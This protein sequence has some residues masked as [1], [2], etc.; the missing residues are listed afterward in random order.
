MYLFFPSYS[1]K[2]ENT[3]RIRMYAYPNTAL[4][5]TRIRMSYLPPS[6]PGLCLLLSCKLPACLSIPTPHRIIKL[7]CTL[8]ILCLSPLI[9]ILKHPL[10][11]PLPLIPRAPH[12]SLHSLGFPKGLVLHSNTVSRSATSSI[13]LLIQTASLLHSYLKHRNLHA[14]T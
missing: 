1:N 8:F 7:L 13:P 9:S 14:P 10:S 2:D 12:F 5:C 4:E 3:I 11:L 6:L